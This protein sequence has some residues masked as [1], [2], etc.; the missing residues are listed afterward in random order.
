MLCLGYTSAVE[1]ASLSITLPKLK[2]TILA[3]VVQLGTV[4]QANEHNNMTIS[5]V[6]KSTSQEV[7]ELKLV[8][9]LPAENHSHSPML[10]GFSS[11]LMLS[12]SETSLPQWSQPKHQSTSIRSFC[13]P[14]KVPVFLP[15]KHP[16]Q[17][18]SSQDV[19]V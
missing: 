8:M 14:Y 11:N 17:R 12:T 3:H 1:G 6:K 2:K 7:R 10:L 19:L 9:V 13:R 4:Q 16:L 15:S 18:K 5:F